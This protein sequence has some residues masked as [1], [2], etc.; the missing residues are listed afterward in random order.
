MEEVQIKYGTVDEL[1]ALFAAK[2]REAPEPVEA[3]TRL[4]VA[5]LLS[6]LGCAIRHVRKRIAHKANVTAR[7]KARKA[8]RAARRINR[9]TRKPRTGNRSRGRV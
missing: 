9:H 3:P 6:Q 1:D 4:Q 8:A 2:L 7:R 5:T